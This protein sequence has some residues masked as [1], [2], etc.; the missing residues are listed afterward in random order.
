[1]ARRSSSAL[2]PPSRRRSC[3]GLRRRSTA[4][5]GIWSMASGAP[6]KAS[7]ADEATLRNALVAAEI[8]LSLVLLAQR[9]LADAH[10]HLARRGSISDSTRR[11][12]LVCPLAFAPGEYADPTE[13]HAFYRAGAAAHRLHCQA[14]EAARRD[15][16]P[17]AVRRPASRA[18]WRCRASRAAIC[19]SPSSSCAPKTI[20]GRSASAFCGDAACR[21]DR[22]SAPSMRSSIETLAATYFKDEDPIGKPIRLTLERR[23]PTGGWTVRDRRRGRG[24]E[25]PGT[26]T[27]DRRL[28]SI[29]PARRPGAEPLSILVRTTR[30]SRQLLNA[31]RDEIAIVDRQVALQATRKPCGVAHR[32]GSIRNPVSA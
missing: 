21:R 12:I 15:D 27:S 18:N 30:G 11:S 29:S 32:A 10:L 5:A 22:G 1:M 20:F 17:A 7:R 13:K 2:E 16:E 26:Q 19:G 3:S 8:A 9:R 31:V 23:D 28:T 4:R 25:E 6:A 24:R 14:V